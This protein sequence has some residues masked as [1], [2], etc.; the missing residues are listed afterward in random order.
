M[1]KHIRSIHELAAT[2]DELYR[3]GIKSW[4]EAQYFMWLNQI[5]SDSSKSLGNE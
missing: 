2:R 5:I 1:E 4:A 3:K